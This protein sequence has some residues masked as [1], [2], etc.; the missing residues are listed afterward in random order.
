[1][2][3]EKHTQTREKPFVS[4]SFS[5]KMPVDTKGRFNSMNPLCV[6]LCEQPSHNTSVTSWELACWRFEFQCI[7]HLSQLLNPVLHCLWLWFP[8]GLT[9]PM[10]CYIY[11]HKGKITLYKEV[12]WVTIKMYKMSPA[13]PENVEH[14]KGFLALISCC[15]ESDCVSCWTR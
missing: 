10:R 4:L 8:N 7:M 3:E 15:S 13:E 11:V 9:A 6:A 5:M 14:C 12:L 2:L 1:M